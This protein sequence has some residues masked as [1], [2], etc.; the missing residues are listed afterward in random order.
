MGIKKING[1]VEDF[2]N[3]FVRSRGGDSTGLDAVTDVKGDGAST[4]PDGH[5]APW[6]V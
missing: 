4:N 2:I 1:G 5:T 6:E 3:K